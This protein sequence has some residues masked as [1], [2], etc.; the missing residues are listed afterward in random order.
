M[1]YDQKLFREMIGLL[2]E[3]GPRRLHQA[4][5]GLEDRDAKQIHHAA[6]TLK[7]LAANFS[8]QATVDAAAAVERLAN[9]NQWGDLP[10]ALARLDDALAELL[11]ALQPLAKSASQSIG[12]S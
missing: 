12:S 3:D 6:H 1:G 7:G 8:A 4:Q 5:Q 2:L 10:Q 9:A 11:A